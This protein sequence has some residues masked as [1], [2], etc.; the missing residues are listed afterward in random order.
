M[1]HPRH[2]RASGD[3]VRYELPKERREN[4]EFGAGC[5]FGRRVTPVRERGG[6]SRVNL[7]ARYRFN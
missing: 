1:P 7:L 4:V 5:L 2:S 3:D 6:M